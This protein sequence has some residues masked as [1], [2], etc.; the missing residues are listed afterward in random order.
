MSRAAVALVLLAAFL[1][2]GFGWRTLVQVRRHGDTG[3]RFERSGPEKVVGPLLLLAFV[4][5]G[6]G[7]V[8]ALAAG[9]AHRP[10]GVASLV[11]GAL[12]PAA[13]AAGVLLALAAGAVT[14][15]AQAQMGASWRIGVQAGERTALITHG[16]Y[17]SVRNPIFTGMLSFGGG[18]AL[19]VPNAPT[20][21]GALLGVVAIEAQVRLVEEPNLR[22]VQGAPYLAWASRTG[23]FVPR[24][25]RLPG[26][27]RVSGA[28]A[29]HR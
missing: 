28:G 6:A 19:L 29:T 22:T 15:V 5:M 8:A 21:I 7:P 14:V 27:G 13:A 9:D 10:G 12:G 3:W 2:A 25:G 11:D 23:R 20:L 26:A 24:L 16:L 18:L 4:L 1:L 17:A